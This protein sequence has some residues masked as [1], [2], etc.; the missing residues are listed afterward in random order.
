MASLPAEV[1]AQ[2]DVNRCLDERLK[3]IEARLG[4]T[5]PADWAYSEDAFCALLADTMAQCTTQTAGA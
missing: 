4:I 2:L 1:T 3:M 5:T